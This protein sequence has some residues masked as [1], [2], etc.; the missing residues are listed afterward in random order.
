MRGTGVDYS[1]LVSVVQLH[2]K[3]ATTLLAKNCSRVKIGLIGPNMCYLRDSITASHLLV[4]DG[5]GLTK[6]WGNIC[7][8]SP[9]NLVT[10][11]L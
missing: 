6:E 8:L 1:Q 3:H 4:N 5:L 9:H 2:Q 11:S 7:Y 10:K